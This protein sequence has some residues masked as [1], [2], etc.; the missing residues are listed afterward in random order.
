MITAAETPNSIRRRAS[1]DAPAAFDVYMTAIVTVD[2]TFGDHHPFVAAAV[3]HIQVRRTGRRPHLDHPRGGRMDALGRR[4]LYL[5]NARGG[6]MNV[7]RLR[8]GDNHPV[9]S[10]EMMT[11]VGPVAV[12][13]ADNDVPRAVIIVGAGMGADVA[14]L[15]DHRPRGRR[16]VVVI[17]KAEAAAF[18]AERKAKQACADGSLN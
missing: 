6:L 10:V 7:D 13:L 11:A 3:Q 15:D 17:V 2:M 18:A 5:D 14:V 16:V 9:G 4:L 12:S 1:M 8:P